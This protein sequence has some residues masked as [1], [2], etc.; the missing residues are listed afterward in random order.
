MRHKFPSIKDKGGL[1]IHL[2]TSK[3]LHRGFGYKTYRILRLAGLNRANRAKAFN[4]VNDTMKS[5]D[6]QYDRETEER[7]LA[8][9][10]A[11]NEIRN[12]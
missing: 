3:D 9:E 12:D 5:W 10:A 8:D 7:R 11:L 6:E 1:K 4:V 2:D